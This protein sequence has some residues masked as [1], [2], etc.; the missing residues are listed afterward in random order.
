MIE[1]SSVFHRAIDQF[2][3]PFTENSLHI[4]LKT[5]KNNI[6]CV[7]LIYGDQYEWTDG[8]WVTH[9]KK[10]EKAGADSTFDYWQL[11]VTPEHRRT[12]YGFLLS[13]DEETLFYT[14]KGFFPQSPEDP[15]QWFC[16]PY[17]HAKEA[18]R[19]PS[20]V[21]DT[22]WYQVFPERFANGDKR[23]NPKDTKAWSSEP[24]SATNFFGGDFQGIL[25]HLDHLVDLGITGIYLTPIF[26]A[27][28][29]HK[30]DS[31]D[32]FE[33]DPQFGDKRLFQKL[34]QKCHKK[35]IK[36]MLDAVFNHCGYYFEPFQDVLKNGEA[37]PYRDW[38]HIKNFPLQGGSTPNYATFG[39]VETM[40]KL[41][42]QN[43]EV[44]EYLLN[45]G[46]YWVKEFDID[47]WRLDVA[48]EIDHAFWREFRT[49]VKKIKPDIFILGE[50]WHDSIAWLRGDQFDSVMNYP[51]LINVVRFFA[52]KNITSKEFVE[53]MTACIHQY[54]DT[55]NETLFNLIGSHDT[56]RILSE[57]GGKVER[58][59]LIFS[60]LMTFTGTPCI[61]YGDEI[62][63][64]GD[65]DPGCRPCMPWE[66]N[67]WNIEI[68]EHVK[69]LIKLRKREKLLCGEGAISFMDAP[70]IQNWIAYVRKNKTNTIFVLLNSSDQKVKYH[71]PFA[72]KGR[73][74]IN[75]KDDHEFASEAEQLSVEVDA[76]D[77]CILKW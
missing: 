26:K 57:C 41:N 31:I 20:W 76:L 5:K 13:D 49:E 21:K 51:F 29:N 45:V 28:S 23:L 35:G 16:F 46:R 8:K 15:N 34:I 66:K 1:R 43:K 70:D 42:T 33:I 71:L 37:S 61:F 30:Y 32:Y 38:F 44:K 36:V 75:L 27:F 14:E 3:Y 48:N 17:L 39:F 7:E 67:Q 2:V 53:S 18:F 69:S 40:P 9:Q 52:Q 6:D 56:P 58:V 74:I 59:K 72:L 24:P 47:G 68:F 10:L 55:V 63:L 4:K 54:P 25:D 12:R 62:G 65:M 73:K 19:A 64:Q 50:I 11:E 22:V 77:I 60:F